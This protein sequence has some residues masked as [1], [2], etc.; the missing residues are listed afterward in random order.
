MCNVC[1]CINVC[2][3]KGGR[4]DILLLSLAGPM[5]VPPPGMFPRHPNMPPGMRPPFM[6]PPMGAGFQ[7]PVAPQSEAP[8]S[9]SNPPA[10]GAPTSS[11]AGT[12]QGSAADGTG[13]VMA[14]PHAMM[15][16]MGAQ[17]GHL[18]APDGTPLDGMHSCFM[19]NW[20]FISYI[21]KYQFK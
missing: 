1:M 6:P 20:R 14:P 19:L 7:I 16:P 2:F 15:P 5:Q 4:L 18:F 11:S 10:S 21:L 9:I 8:T 13:N 12:I 3:L 17:A